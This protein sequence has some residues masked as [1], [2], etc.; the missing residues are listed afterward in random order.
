MGSECNTERADISPRIHLPYILGCTSVLSMATPPL[1]L[2][3][4]D[5]PAACE[6]ASTGTARSPERSARST[7]HL[8]AA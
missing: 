1:Y 7:S 8:R 3:Y 5:I 4:E 2:G 6:S